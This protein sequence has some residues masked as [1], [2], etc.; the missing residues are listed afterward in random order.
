MNDLKPKRGPGRPPKPRL[1][2]RDGIPAHIERAAVDAYWSAC[3]KHLDRH[4]DGRGRRDPN[5]YDRKIMHLREIP[6][7]RATLRA[8][9]TAAGVIDE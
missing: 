1:S 4:V 7:I 8:A 9:F 3:R 5:D 2:F 6:L